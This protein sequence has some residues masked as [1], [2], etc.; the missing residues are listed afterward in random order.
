MKEY[1]KYYGKCDKHNKNVSIEVEII[2]DRTFE[3]ND[4]SKNKI[5]HC[6]LDPNHKCKRNECLI[7]NNINF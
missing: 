3:G 4:Y 5:R 6:P 2:V 7:W 1:K